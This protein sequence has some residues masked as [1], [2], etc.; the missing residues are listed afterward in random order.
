MVPSL[1]LVLNCPEIPNCDFS[2][3]FEL[4][5][6]VRPRSEMPSTNP[7]P[8]SG[9]GMRKMT[10]CAANAAGKF[11]CLI[12]QPG[13][14]GRPDI[15]YSSCT[16]PSGVPSGFCTKRASRTGPF[17]VI[18]GGTTLWAPC[19]V[20]TATCGLAVGFVPPKA[21]CAWQPPHELRLY[22][23]PKPGPPFVKPFGASLIL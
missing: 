22:R 19:R 3:A 7:R 8:K 14:S 13:A 12:L 15:T 20:A 18:K 2:A 5:A 23:G 6:V 9:V 21:G 16:W 1:G 11:S 4:K 10:L 17:K